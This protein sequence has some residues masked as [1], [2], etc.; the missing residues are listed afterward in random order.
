MQKFQW[1]TDQH[2]A[3]KL[4]YWNPGIMGLGIL[5]FW[6]IIPTFH[7]PIIPFFIP[8]ALCVLCG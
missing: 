6:P 1:D 5:F 8:C 7:P 2:G 3:N 4:E